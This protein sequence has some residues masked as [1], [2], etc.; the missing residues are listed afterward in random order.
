MC[1]IRLVTKGKKQ[2]TKISN[3]FIDE[4]MADANGS[5]VKI[6]I[7]LLRCISDSHNTSSEGLEFAL[8]A[9]ADRLEYTEKDI[10]RALRY[11]AKKG[12]LE[13]AQNN[14]GSI[15]WIALADLAEEES[16]E[17]EDE[18]A[19]AVTAV[20]QAEMKLA[21]S[22]KNT[23]L[24]SI[25]D[26]DAPSISKTAA[27]KPIKKTA[28]SQDELSDQIFAQ[29]ESIL[30]RPLA[31]K[32]IQAVLYCI[33][34][35][36]FPSELI[37]FL[38]EHCKSCDKTAANYVQQVAVNWHKQ[39]ITT[40]ED[41][42]RSVNSYRASIRAA[43]K[44]LGMVGTPGDSLVQYINR[45]ERELHMSAELIREAC[46]RTYLA[47]K[48]NHLQYAD[49]ILNRWHTSGAH[50]LEELQTLDRA[51]EAN[52]KRKTDADNRG[53]DANRFHNFTQRD[54]SSDEMEEIERKLRGF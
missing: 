20:E 52:A 31:P 48:S 45:W 40:V 22:T 42:E 37:R 11:W 24:P 15:A 50:S 3:R 34:A 4:Y 47:T 9:M 49:S 21:K 51:H 23:T 39:G 18:A 17:A 2:F 36:Q 8:S 33:E 28:P 41:A 27:V 53:T 10:L 1:K 30:E 35:L 32:D 38:Y 26:A 12:V 46:K 14:D 6:Y 7:Y 13:F 54:Y 19:M 43:M 25:A 5:Y 29:V 16:R 44:E